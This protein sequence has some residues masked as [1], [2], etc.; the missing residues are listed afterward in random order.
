MDGR[1]QQHHQSDSFSIANLLSMQPKHHPHRPV[2]SDDPLSHLRKLTTHPD[3]D[4]S[5]AMLAIHHHHYHPSAPFYCNNPVMGQVSNHP[6]MMATS[7]SAPDNFNVK[8][9]ET[10]IISSDSGIPSASGEQSSTD[11][12]DSA[13]SGKWYI[14]NSKWFRSK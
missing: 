14:F 3:G 11:P 12:A 5:E 13:D 6:V 4:N 9:E 8:A 10:I 2:H 7:S 1:F